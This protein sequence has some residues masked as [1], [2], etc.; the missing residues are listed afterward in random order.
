MSEF[1]P[2]GKSFG[3]P[4]VL[5]V[6]ANAEEP[7]TVEEIA[8]N[9]PLALSGIQNVMQELHRKGFVVRRKKKDG[10]HGPN[11]YEYAIAYKELDT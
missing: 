8:E 10:S 5:W 6:V 9:C 7:I 11:P 2:P 3:Q 4:G 1:G